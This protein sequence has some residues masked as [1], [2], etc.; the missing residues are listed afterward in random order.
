MCLSACI[1]LSITEFTSSHISRQTSSPQSLFLVPLSLIKIERN[2]YSLSK[3]IGQTRNRYALHWKVFAC[4]EVSFSVGTT[5]SA[6]AAKKVALNQFLY[7]YERLQRSKILLDN[8]KH[9][10]ICAAVVA[11]NA[12]KIEVFWIDCCLF[13]IPSGRQCLLSIF[14]SGS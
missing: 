5:A 2:R 9:M 13:C 6:A 1:F 10:F 8:W 11:F 14:E 3:I 12:L 7:T 4:Q